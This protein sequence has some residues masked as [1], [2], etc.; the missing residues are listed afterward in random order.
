MSLFCFI[1]Q[2]KANA[3]YAGYCKRHILIAAYLY[4]AFITSAVIADQTPEALH[5]FPRAGFF[6][7]LGLQA[8]HR[9]PVP[10][11]YRGNPWD[12]IPTERVS[13]DFCWPTSNDVFT[14]Q[15]GC[16]DRTKRKARLHGGFF[17]V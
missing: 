4:T 10:C 6:F 2:Q 7:I 11:R 1:Y 13:L 3:D 17:A 12:T 14:V 5:T 8:N 15:Q 9:G 16:D